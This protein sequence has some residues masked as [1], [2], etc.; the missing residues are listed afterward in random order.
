MRNSIY[1]VINLNDSMGMAPSPSS[2][3]WVGGASVW[4]RPACADGQPSLKHCYT[5]RAQDPAM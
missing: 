2:V 5:P 4:Q 3:S 1:M